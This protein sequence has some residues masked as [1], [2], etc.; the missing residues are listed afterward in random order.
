MRRPVGEVLGED[1]LP[2]RVDGELDELAAQIGLGRT[3]EDRPAFGRPQMLGPNQLDRGAVVDGRLR[4]RV[5]ARAYVDLATLQELRGLGAAGPPNRNVLLDGI[6][7]LEG[8]VEIER[9]E[10]LAGDA[11]GQQRL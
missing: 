11:V 4:A 3:L 6:E 1:R 2:R 10:L 9:I 7:L 5:P 8:P